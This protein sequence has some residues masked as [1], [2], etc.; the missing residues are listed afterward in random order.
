MFDLAAQHGLDPEILAE[1]VLAVR[2]DLHDGAAPVAVADAGLRRL[3]RLG[4]GGMAEVWLATDPRLDRTVAMKILR[5]ELADHPVARDRFVREAQATA[6]LSHP[7]IVPVHEVGELADGRPFFTMDVVRG[8]T[9]GEVAAD[10]GRDSASV[11]RLVGIFRRA[12]DAVAYAHDQGL[13]HRDLK[14]ANVMV[15]EF[16]TVFVLDWGLVRWSEAL[17]H[18][19]AEPGLTAVG[20]VQGTPGYLAPEQA[21]GEATGPHSDVYALGIVLWELLHRSP[22][23]DPSDP[24]LA[25]ALTSA[26]RVPPC[27]EGP[28]ALWSI[29]ASATSADPADRPVDGAALGRALD[30]W[31]DGE[32]RR[33]AATREV[34]RARALRDEER[35]LR[36]EGQH[37][38]A[39]AEALL[40]QV[41][42]HADVGAKRVGWAQQDAARAQ[43][44]RAERLQLQ[45]LQALHGALTH[46][47][48]HTD[49]LAALV[50]HWHGLHVGCEARRDRTGARE[51]LAQLAFYDRGEHA[52][53][54]SG[55][56]R[57]TVRT[58]PAGVSATLWRFEE[59]ERQLVPVDPRVLG[60][61][62]AVVEDLQ[63]GSYVLRFE[64]HPTV[65]PVWMRRCADLE[66][67]PVRLLGRRLP[68]DSCLVPAGPFFEGTPTDAFQSRPWE[69]VSVDG[70]V[71]AKHPVTHGQ[72]LD[73]IND[74][75]DRGRADEALAFAPR[76]RGGPDQAG[77]LCYTRSPDGHFALAPDADGDRWDRRWPVFLVDVSRA[78]AYAAWRAETDGLPWRLP[79]ELEWEKAA[80]GVDGRSYPWGDRFDPSFACVRS[81]HPGRPLPA[82]VD[83]YPVDCSV[84][85]V[86]G[87]SGNLRDWCAD[88]FELIGAHPTSAGAQRVLKGGCWY[89]PE[90]GAHL[91]A[92]YGLDGHNH[93][94][95]VSFRL[96][97]SLVAADYG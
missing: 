91:A 11:R 20:A 47:A 33:L 41:P 23:F 40:A 30:V 9:L 58:E 95:T 13:L 39:A 56:G 75:V 55:R 31:I 1:I 8:R 35:R 14:P 4:R 22:A 71:M 36:S 27:T 83:A 66:P 53:Y 86:R 26:G 17:E 51:A 88:P 74:L 45:R 18:L 62:P 85:G 68:A 59:R 29:V 67:P 65:L 6:R 3:D 32:A 48:E 25:I 73:F 70:F 97:R 64:G 46:D 2:P 89:F 15:G 54:L 43:L 24:T 63:M 10:I 28:P 5:P 87:M 92:R 52:A 61:T 96:A 42:A 93:G 34:E 80:R 79:T 60:P 77:Q 90:S 69:E 81:S 37:A 49:A 78:E 84:Y 50:D 19:P 44:A 94:D 82:P 16:G 76:E 57:L 38:L 7:G 21:R 12:V 72:F